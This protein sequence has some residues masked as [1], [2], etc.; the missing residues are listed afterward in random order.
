MS[1]ETSTTPST[2]P[3]NGHSSDGTP[4]GAAGW[5]D[6]VLGLVCLAIAA[7]YTAEARTFDG[8]AFAT[9]PVGPKTMPTGVGVLFG[10]L[11]LY[12]ILK[13]DGP[14][15][16]PTRQAS[17]QIGL[18]VI[19]SYIYGRVME[20]IGFIAASAVMMAVI[21]LLFRAPP[22][23]LVPLSVLFPTLLAFVFNNWLELRLPAGWWG[24]F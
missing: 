20:P 2:T 16:W 7:W 22:K 8:T 13:P 14:P 6:R 24:G 9:G 18:V 11:A 1:D 5:S 17:W 15:R 10:L 23:K 21:G 4:S 12:L 3:D 19:S